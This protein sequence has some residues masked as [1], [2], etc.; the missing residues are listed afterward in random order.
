VEAEELAD[1]DMVVAMDREN[2]ADLRGLGGGLEA[3]LRL[4]SEFLPG[5]SPA[6]VPDPYYGGPEG[7]DRVIDLV[8]IGCARLLDELLGESTEGG[9]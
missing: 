1:W 3:P 8:E 7:F 5:G 2:L 4:F 9:G 6:D